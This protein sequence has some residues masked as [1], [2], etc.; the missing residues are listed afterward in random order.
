M[1][2]SLIAAS[3]MIAAAIHSEIASDEAAAPYLTNINKEIA[4]QGDLIVLRNGQKL[5]GRIE[6]LPPLSYSFKTV[7]F[8]EKDLAIII[9]FLEGNDKKAHYVTRDGHLYTGN[10]PG[11]KLIFHDLSNSEGT[12]QAFDPQE[13]EYIALKRKTEGALSN[14]RKTF[15]IELKDGNRFPAILKQET[16]TISN[17]V[18]EQVL[19]T[20]SIIRLVFAG[21]VHGYIRKNGLPQKIKLSFVKDPYL[22]VQI[23]HT[24]DIIKLPCDHI[25]ML[26]EGNDFSL[27]KETAAGVAAFMTAGEA[28]TSLEGAIGAVAIASEVFHSLDDVAFESPVKGTAQ[29]EVPPIFTSMVFEQFADIAFEN[30]QLEEDEA[31]LTAEAILGIAQLMAEQDIDLNSESETH[32]LIE[33][34]PELSRIKFISAAEKEQQE[35]DKVVL[36]LDL[37]PISKPVVF[38]NFMQEI[39]ENKAMEAEIGQPFSVG[40]IVER[41]KEKQ[42]EQAKQ[43]DPSKP[44]GMIYISPRNATQEKDLYGFYVDQYPVSNLDYKNFVDA[45][46]YHMPLHWFEGKIPNGLENEPVVNVSYKDA[47]TYAVWAG[48][49]LPTDFEVN[50]AAKRA[51]LA[52]QRIYEWTATSVSVGEKRHGSRNI[53]EPKNNNYKEVYNLAQGRVSYMYKHDCN[54]N[55]GFRCVLDARGSAP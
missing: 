2:K 39:Q 55:T 48:K 21:G 14:H 8:K 20:N 32:E 15:S 17:G 26:Q 7:P 23:C 3:F 19:E 38:E 5:C 31:R 29:K 27:P 24:C 46:H 10:L 22:A 18:K 50:Y 45:T 54:N 4:C 49:R 12:K 33:E 6:K 44:S 41:P 53:S 51:V 43:V 40:S 1:K 37:I 42:K 11:E 34:D 9:F 13:I 25:V 35:G 36:E 16:I 52:N 47:V 30:R 28:P